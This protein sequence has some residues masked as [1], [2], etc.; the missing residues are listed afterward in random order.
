MASRMPTSPGSPARSRDARRACRR[1]PT[2]IGYYYFDRVRARR[3]T[4]STSRSRRARSPRRRT[5]AAMTR[6]TATVC[7]TACGN[8]IATVTSRSERLRRQHRLRLLDAVSRSS[9]AR[10]RRAT[11]RTIRKRGRSPTITVGGVDLYEG[12]GHRHARTPGKDKTLTMFSSLVPAMLNVM[13]GNDGSCVASTIEAA[14]AWM[15]PYRPGRQRRACVQP[16][17]EGRRAAAPSD[18]QLQQRHALRA[19]SRLG[20]QVGRDNEVRGGHRGPP[21]SRRAVAFRCGLADPGTGPG[22]GAPV[23]ACCG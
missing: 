16:R 17:L 14:N 11:G 23:T 6:S 18:G 9:P 10:A 8:S 7:R 20:G 3:R 2:S 12:A 21:A 1:P 19:A 13:V 4:R 22:R 15:A 5:R